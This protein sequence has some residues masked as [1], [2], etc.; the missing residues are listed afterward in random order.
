MWSYAKLTIWACL[1]FLLWI[2]LI[3]IRKGRQNCLTY[4]L[5]RWDKEGGYLCIRWCRSNKFRLIKWPHFMYLEQKYHKY[6]VH[7]VPNEDIQ[8]CIPTPWFKPKI[9]IGDKPET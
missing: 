4:A 2:L 7:A 9:K 3:P 1:W 5:E 8:E 6:I